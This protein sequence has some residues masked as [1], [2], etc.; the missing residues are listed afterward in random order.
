[1]KELVSYLLDPL[2]IVAYMYVGLWVWET[3]APAKPLPRMRNWKAIGIAF[4]IFNFVLA[5]ILPLLV[6]HHL[7]RFQLLDLSKLNPVLAAFVGV[8]IYEGLLYF[9]HRALHK[10][11]T[12]WKLF[13]QLHHSTERLD[14]P[15]AF[16]TGP[17]DTI[18]FTFLGSLS[19]VLVLGISAKATTI[20]IVFLTFLSLFQ[21]ANIKTPKWLGYFIQRPESHSIHHGRRVHRYNYADIPLYDIIFGT[22][23]NPEKHMKETGFYNGA[24]YRI[25]EMLAMRDV[26]K[27]IER[28]DKIRETKD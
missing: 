3:K 5:S 26:S 17:F 14:I 10:F 13:H 28:I 19:F 2:A 11:D 6:D 23:K 7:A 9:W 24:S 4:F 18:M 27:P 20:A 21:H 12:L 16:Y 1:M 25:L 22:F 8:F 15:S